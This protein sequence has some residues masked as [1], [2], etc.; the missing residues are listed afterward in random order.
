MY[1]QNIILLLQNYFVKISQLQINALLAP[2]LLV[3]LQKMQ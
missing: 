2:E 3:N 1:I